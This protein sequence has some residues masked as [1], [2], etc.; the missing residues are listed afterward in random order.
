MR[1]LILILLGLTVSAAAAIDLQ[2]TDRDQI[3]KDATGLALR[4]GPVDPTQ[5][6]LVVFHAGQSNRSNINPTLYVPAHTLQI[7]N[8]NISDGRLYEIKG[9]MLGA[10]FPAP[11]NRPGNISAR[12]DD[13]IIEKRIADRVISVPLAVNSEIR[14]WSQGRLSTRFRIA[15]K[16]LAALGI[17]PGPRVKFIV[18]WSQGPT[19]TRL[20]TT[21]P[22][23]KMH[24]LRVVADAE[25][26]EFSGR[27]YVST[28][29]WLGG[30]TAPQIQAAQI[31]VCDEERIFQSFNADALDARYR[32]DSAGHF[33]DEGASLV[34]A[35]VVAAILASGP[36]FR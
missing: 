6:T 15:V 5:R 31:I 36:L 34:A 8:L 24:F 17:V 4:N 28:E 27:W 26:A 14:D 1:W 22:D 10:S 13:L 3:Y 23:W 11:P 20:G 25:A 19:D 33:N 12:I 9:P 30:I 29:T 18:D 7:D 32:A 35:G 16:Q 2:E 21:G